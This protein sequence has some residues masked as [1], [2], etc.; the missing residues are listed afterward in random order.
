MTRCYIMNG[1]PKE[2][3]EAYINMETSSESF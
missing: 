3:W 1:K 2:A